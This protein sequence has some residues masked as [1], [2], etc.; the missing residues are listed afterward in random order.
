MPCRSIVIQILRDETGASAIEYGLILA[1]LSISLIA[2]LQGLAL[3]V[4]AV[5]DTATTNAQTALS[6]P[7]S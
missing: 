6:P 3:G 2:A 4:N 5:W 7:S 1:M